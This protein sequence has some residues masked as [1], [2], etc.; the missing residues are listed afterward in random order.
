MNAYSPQPENTDT[1]VL[2]DGV[3]SCPCIGNP[4]AAASVRLGEQ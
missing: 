4:L 1:T 2:E 3:V